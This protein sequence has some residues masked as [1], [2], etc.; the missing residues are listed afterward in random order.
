MKIFGFEILKKSDVDE[1]KKENEKLSNRVYSERPNI[2]ELS[3]Y[4]QNAIKN[5]IYPLSLYT[6]YQFAQYSSTFAIVI[7]ALQREIFKNGVNVIPNFKFKCTKCGEE[8][9]KDLD[10]KCDSCNAPLRIPSHIDEDVLKR[11]LTFINENDQ[12]L[13]DL[14][15]QIEKDLEVVDDAYIVAL[16]EYEIEG[17]HITSSTVKELVRGDPLVFKIIADKS[18]R[19]AKNQEG[20]NVYFCV[21]H[22]GVLT[23]KTKCSQ[24]G[25]ETVKAYYKAETGAKKVIYYGKDDVVHISKYN[26]SPTYG[27]PPF[28]A[29]WMKIAILLNQD[30]YMQD[31]YFKQRPPKGLLWTNSGNDEAIRKSFELNTMAIQKNPHGIYPFVTGDSESKFEWIDFGLTVEE[32]KYIE[33]RNEFKRE[34]S[35]VFGVMPIYLGDV[36]TTGG[37]ATEREQMVV[38]AK[39]V[40][41]GQE[42]YNE[43]IFPW[44]CKQLGVNDYTFYLEK[45]EEADVMADIQIKIAKADLALAMAKLGFDVDLDVHGG[46]VYKKV[47]ISTESY[48][49]GVGENPQKETLTR[50]G[51]LGYAGKQDGL[52]I[53]GKRKTQRTK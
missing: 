24:C 29:I 33:T 20:K 41:M 45:H 46:F 10:M 28:F 38:T 8:Y 12:N 1:L 44:L 21:A 11:W 49:R 18:G 14:L 36:S 50:I 23:E 52:V 15:Y 6:I 16:K 13:I 35:A 5:P 48:E 42:I 25:L 40:E 7:R 32:L 39:A 53:D 26:P 37:F 17:K 31:W 43:K 47:K 2:D 22:N 9:E 19:P 34:C 3:F 51:E 30:K 27:I 4:T